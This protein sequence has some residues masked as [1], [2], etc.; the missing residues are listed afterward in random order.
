MLVGL[1]SVSIGGKRNLFSEK[2][3][4]CVESCSD[5]DWWIQRKR[6]R[7]LLEYENIGCLPSKESDL[8]LLEPQHPLPN[9]FLSHTKRRRFFDELRDRFKLFCA[10]DWYRIRQRD[11]F[12]WI[13][14]SRSP[15]FYSTQLKHY[16]NE[17][18]EG[19][20][21]RAL[22]SVYPEYKWMVWKFPK[23]PNCY[24]DNVYVRKELIYWIGDQL[25]LENPEDWYKVKKSLALKCVNGRLRGSWFKMLEGAYCESTWRWW[26]CGRTPRGFWNDK[27]NV[28]QFSQWLLKSTPIRINEI[29][30]RILRSFGGGNIC[31]PFGGFRNF[32]DYLE[33]EAPIDTNKYKYEY[34]EDHD[35]DDDNNDNDKKKSHMRS[36]RM[37]CFSKC[38]SKAQMHLLRTIRCL[39]PEENCGEVR[40]NHCEDLFLLQ[41]K[42]R[43]KHIRFELDVFLPRLSL[44]FEYQGE[45]HYRMHPLTGPADLQQSRD[46]FKR[47]LCVSRGITLIEV[48]SRKWDLHAASLSVALLDHRPDLAALMSPDSYSVVPRYL[49]RPFSGGFLRATVLTPQVSDWNSYSS[50]FALNRQYV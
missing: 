35:D 13:A 33:Q 1:G 6:Q 22:I 44:A 45:H 20:L 49:S 31:I 4:I 24:W 30:Y 12:R 23:V 2:R 29:S 37:H 47:Q 9:I 50:S 48:D 16:L 7:I 5:Y 27:K 10:E 26:L 46:L 40:T 19:S 21:I 42:V 43:R 17:F 39:L 14:L 18:Y 36:S 28:L 38:T 11:L 8:L 34:D 15:V 25:G 32:I 3:F 41:A